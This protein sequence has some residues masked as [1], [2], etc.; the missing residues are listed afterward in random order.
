MGTRLRFV[1][2]SALVLAF[3]LSS[4]PAKA[5]DAISLTPVLAACKDRQQRVYAVN[6]SGQI[7][8]CSVARL[9]WKWSALK[10]A[11]VR[12]C[13]SMEVVP[14]SSQ[15]SVYG[16]DPKKAGRQIVTLF[17]QGDSTVSQGN[18]FEQ[19]CRQLRWLGP[20]VFAAL[21]AN[22]N[23]RQSRYEDGLVFWSIQKSGAV[24]RG[25]RFNDCNEAFVNDIARVDDQLALL[26]LLGGDAS[27]ASKEPSSQLVLYDFVTDR[28]IKRVASSLARCPCPSL[29]MSNNQRFVCVFNANSYEVR[30]LPSLELK[31]K[32]SY[33]ASAAMQAAV[34]ND[35]DSV[36]LGTGELRAWRRGADESFVLS[37]LNED[38]IKTEW[39]LLAR[40][41]TKD[42]QR[43]PVNEA[44]YRSSFL[45]I[46]VSFIGAS[47]DVVA[48]TGD[49]ELR[50]WTVE[51]GELIRRKQIASV[52]QLEQSKRWLRS[53]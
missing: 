31:R 26:H 15:I 5:D 19:S 16:S 45:V 20:S 21:R 39:S 8:S 1:C 34:S 17:S 10:P 28:E 6:E 25:K 36:V 51:R 44:V 48:I 24:T 38:L 11:V 37:S 2:C 27:D 52:S 47:N 50:V 4:D 9:D 7:G 43:T 30:E 23:P 29:A 14:G 42:W 3:L 32:A 46:H 18:Q 13:L 33:K 49:G 35:G 41:K 12:D 40:K 53:P 22:Y